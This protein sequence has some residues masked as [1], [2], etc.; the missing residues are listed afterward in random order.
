MSGYN[1]L[2]LWASRPSLQ[3][4][5][6]PD[7]VAPNRGNLPL[8]PPG[9]PVTGRLTTCKFLQ[10]AAIVTPKFKEKNFPQFSEVNPPLSW[11]LAVCHSGGTAQRD[12]EGEAMSTSNQAVEFSAALSLRAAETMRWYALHTRA[13]H[14]KVVEHRLREYG[15]ETYLPTVQ[16][17]HRWSDRKKRVEAPLFSCYLFLRCALTPQDRNQV[18]RIGSVLGFVG[19]GAAGMAIPDDQIESV[20]TLLSQASPWRSHPFLKAGQRVRIR[21]GALDGVEGIFVSENGDRSLVVSVDAIQR[22]LAVRID[23]Y[24]VE[25][26]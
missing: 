7:W 12:P 6:S 18:Y 10:I 17:V 19:G 11:K 22:S 24:D 20:R 9:E 23:G 1:G 4:N 8:R 14:E 15:M 5:V 3:G 16:E 13:R 2:L 26:A 25:P 21:G